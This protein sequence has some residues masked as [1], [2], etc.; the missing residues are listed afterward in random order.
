MPLSDT[1]TNINIKPTKKMKYNVYNTEL[2]FN[3]GD[4]G[5][6]QILQGDYIGTITVNEDDEIDSYDF[7][8]GYELRSDHMISECIGGEWESL[9][10]D[11]K[12][13]NENSCTHALTITEPGPD[14]NG[15]YP[16][17]I[18]LLELADA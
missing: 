7:P 10:G 11:T 9:D 4:E 15:E 14:D 18:Y 17:V 13:I 2:D 6:H 3:V 8:G 1:D 16:E 5:E 12:W